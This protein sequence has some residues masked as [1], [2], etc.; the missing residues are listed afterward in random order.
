MRFRVRPAVPSRFPLW[1]HPAFRGTACHFWRTGIP[2]P[3]RGTVRQ[4]RKLLYGATGGRPALSTEPKKE[5][6]MDADAHVKPEGDRT[7]TS[8]E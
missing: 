3:G 1:G 5:K 7:R 8:D 4:R 2:P 6:G